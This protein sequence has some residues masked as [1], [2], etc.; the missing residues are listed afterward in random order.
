MNKVS[1]ASS[2]PMIAVNNSWDI[3]NMSHYL[4]NNR[5]NYEAST[6]GAISIGLLDSDM[7]DTSYTMT[8][9]TSTIRR[10]EYAIHANY[11]ATHAGHVFNSLAAESVMRSYKSDATLNMFLHP[12]PNT[13]EEEKRYD[14][15]NQDVIV[16]FVMLAAPC[17]PAAFATFVVRERETR[18]KQQ[19]LVSGVSIPAYWISTWYLIF[20]LYL[21]LKNMSYHLLHRNYL[22]LFVILFLFDC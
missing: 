11:T 19:Q 14:S 21:E 5:D 22:Y 15:F 13:Y 20:L 17:I 4:H 18:S 9:S 8:S 16:T 10:F 7:D 12:L 6:F 3:K 1:Y 2:A